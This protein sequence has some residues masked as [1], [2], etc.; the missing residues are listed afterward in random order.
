MNVYLCGQKEFGAAV[1][2]KLIADGHS[3]VGACCPL[4]GSRGVDRAREAANVYGIPVSLAGTLCAATLPSGIDLIVCAHSH[5]FIGAA[6]RRKAVH[7]AVGFHPSL[8]PRHRGRDAVRWTI[9]MGDAIAGGS[10]YWL[11]DRMDAGPIASQRY[12]FVDRRDTAE[13]LWREKLFPMGV[14]LLTTVVSD[15]SS[16][17]IVKA[18]QAE[19]YSTF[20]P[21]C[22]PPPIRRPDLPRLEGPGAKKKTY[23]T[24]PGDGYAWM[25]EE[26]L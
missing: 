18:R 7:G 9:K 16:G 8:L 26:V 25:A 21:A 3:V 2:R 4:N 23:I 6:T 10:V 13:T 14:Q 17:R 20:E 11:D 12:C 5:D 19:R 24:V 1:L 22:N 15:V